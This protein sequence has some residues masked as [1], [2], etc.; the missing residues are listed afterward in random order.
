M[1]SLKNW[2]VQKLIMSWLK[3]LL[4]KLPLDG[5]KTVLGVILAGIGVVLK[6]Y[7]AGPV[8][9]IANYALELMR[10]MDIAPVT[11][12][13]TLTIISGSVTAVIGAIHKLLKRKEAKDSGLPPANTDF[14]V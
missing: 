10:T 9:E 14:D 8:F 6:F 1:G 3:G 5:L 4:D 11:D 13:A 12:P 7:P 2:I